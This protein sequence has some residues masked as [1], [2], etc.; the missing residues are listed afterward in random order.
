MLSA[1]GLYELRFN[2]RL[3]VFVLDTIRAVPKIRIAAL[4]PAPQP[5]SAGNGAYL[6][7][8]GGMTPRIL[9]RSL[10]PWL[11][12]NRTCERDQPTAIVA[13]ICSTQ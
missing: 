11:L 8:L 5:S 3:H 7:V 12:A 13:A 10:V 4:S 1:I 6:S 9:R 2:L